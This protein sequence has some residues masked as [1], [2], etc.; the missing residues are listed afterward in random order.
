MRGWGSCVRR[1]R[2]SVQLARSVVADRSASGREPPRRWLLA[3]RL[4]KQA[5]ECVCGVAEVVQ[6]G[7]TFVGGGLGW[8][9]DDA[10]CR[11]RRQCPGWSCG[12][13]SVVS[14]SLVFQPSRR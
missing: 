3:V 7:V 14:W 9:A 12:R 8:L 4:A 11:C 5:D 1:Y 10:A 2:A 6:G 13:R